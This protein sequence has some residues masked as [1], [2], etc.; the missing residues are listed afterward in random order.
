MVW[1]RHRVVKLKPDLLSPDGPTITIPTK[2]QG[3]SE[4]PFLTKRK[5]IYYYFYTLGGDE[6]YQYAYMMSRTSPI[7][8]WEAP[9]QDIIA[10]T[11]PA[12]KVLG[13]ATA[14]SSIRKAAN[15]G[16]SSISN[17]G[18]AAPPGRFMPTR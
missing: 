9:E 6:N 15:N 12:A 14:A 13:Q 18:A 2:R 11:D 10:T 8:P 7:G 16:I 4:G 3:Y 1:S 17:S 5:G